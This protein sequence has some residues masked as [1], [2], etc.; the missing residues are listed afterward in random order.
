VVEGINRTDEDYEV[1]TARVHA[2]MSDRLVRKIGNAAFRWCENLIK[3]TAPFVEEVGGR[4]FVA[5]YNFRHVVLNPFEGVEPQAFDNC[6]SLK[7][8]AVWG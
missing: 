4:T 1:A 5:T 7:V 2:V 3:V 6:L 8:L